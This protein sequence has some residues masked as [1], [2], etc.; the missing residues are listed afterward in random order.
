[1]GKIEKSESGWKKKGFNRNAC[2][3]TRGGRKSV[4]FNDGTE[5]KNLARQAMPQAQTRKE[6]QHGRQDNGQ[7]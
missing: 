7:S 1:V 4:A 6:Q 5:Q 3:M 2:T